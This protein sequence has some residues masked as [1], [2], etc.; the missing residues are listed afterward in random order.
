MLYYRV[1]NQKSHLKYLVSGNSFRKLSCLAK[2]TNGN[3]YSA[4][5]ALACQSFLAHFLRANRKL[6]PLNKRLRSSDLISLLVLPKYFEDSKAIR[7]KRK[8]PEERSKEKETMTSFRFCFA[9]L[10]L[11]APE[12]SPA[13]LRLTIWRRR[14]EK[15]QA[16]IWRK[17]IGPSS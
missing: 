5:P 16:E 8:R 3:F 1:V 17:R 4:E 6:S 7:L 12:A 15:Q 2:F 9:L 13:Q 10:I 14:K 11:S